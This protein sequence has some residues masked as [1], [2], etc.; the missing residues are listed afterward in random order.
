MT[1]VQDSLQNNCFNV[2]QIAAAVTVSWSA[3]RAEPRAPVDGGVNLGHFHHV[4]LRRAYPR[5]PYGAKYRLPCQEGPIA[6]LNLHT[7]SRRPSTGTASRAGRLLAIIFAC[8]GAAF[9]RQW[10]L[11]RC[12]GRVARLGE[13]TGDVQLANEREDWHPISRNF[14]VT[15]GDNLWVSDGGRAELDVGGLQFWL[16]VAPMFIRTIRRFC[17]RRPAD[18]G[19]HDRACSRDGIWRRHASAAAGE[20]ALLEPGFTWSVRAPVTRGL[21][22]ALT[23]RRGRAEV[24]AGGAPQ[25]VNRGETVVLDGIGVR[26]DSYHRDCPAVSKHGPIRAT[27]ASTAGKVAMAAIATPG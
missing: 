23:V 1:A 24:V 12:A 15:A 22:G 11:G 8:V 20:L 19:R 25:V 7:L 14:A 27:A 3:A 17:G 4:N 16:L 5:H 18:A 9:C 6:M 26:Y 10:R 21:S 2:Q 13:Y